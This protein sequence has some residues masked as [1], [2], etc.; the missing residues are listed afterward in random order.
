MTL[1][2][3]R[4]REINVKANYKNMYPDL[5]CRLCTSQNVEETQY[6]LVNCDVLISK[7]KNLAQNVKIEYE[8]IFENGAKQ[9][10]AAKLLHEVIEIRRTLIDQN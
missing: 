10:L 7:C 8:D 4:V 5:K 2:K 9:V 6:H 3:L 1:F